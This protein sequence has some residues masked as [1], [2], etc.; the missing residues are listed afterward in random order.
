MREYRAAGRWVGEYTLKTKA[1][2]YVGIYLKRG[3]LKKTACVACGDPVVQAH[4]ADYSKPLE[5]TWLCRKHHTDL[6]KLVE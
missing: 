2:A 4:H 1:R 6:H 5:V 3:H